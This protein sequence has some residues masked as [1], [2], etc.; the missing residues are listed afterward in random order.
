MILERRTFVAGS[1]LLPASMLL[2]ATARAALAILPAQTEGPY[3]PPKL[4]ADTDNDL[5][6][7][8]DAAKDAGGEILELTGIVRGKDGMP[9]PGTGIEIWQ[10][11]ADGHYIAEGERGRRDQWFQ[12]YGRMTVGEDG[13]YRFRTIKPVPYGGRTA[14][15]HVKLHPPGRPVLTSQLYIAGNEGN[16]RDSLYRRLDAE[17]R[18][19]A[20]MVLE[21]ADPATA[22]WRTARDL[23]LG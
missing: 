20:D 9:I 23:V 7:I 21:A 17:G 14:H 4:P 19:A 13:A 11:D 1:L 8:A 5:V 22:R 6:R 12:G 2:P 10:C 15:I 18:E 16:E 3:Y